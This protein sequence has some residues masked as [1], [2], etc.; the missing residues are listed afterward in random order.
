MIRARIAPNA[1]TLGN[2][3]FLALARAY[4][5]DAVEPGSLDALC[6]AAVAALSAPGPTRIRMRPGLA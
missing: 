5:A 2:S 3:D 1:V 4:G 6:A